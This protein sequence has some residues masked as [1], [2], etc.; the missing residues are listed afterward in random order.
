L[1]IRVAFVSV[2]PSPYQRDLFGAL[3]SRDELDLQVF[4]LERT[5]PDSPWPETSLRPFESILPGFCLPAGGVRTHFNVPPGLGKFDLV[6]LNSLMAATAQWLMRVQLRYRKWVFWGER[7]R[8]TTGGFRRKTHGALCSVLKNATAIAAVGTRAKTDYERRFPGVPVYNI[9][10]H[11]NLERFQNAAAEK[12]ESGPAPIFLFCGQMIARKGI[13][14]LLKAFITLVSE[15]PAVRLLL[16]GREAELPLLLE[17]L[18]PEVGDR[19]EY[20][21]FQ[22]PADLPRFFARGDIFVLPSRYDGWGVVVNQAIGAGLPI[23]CSDEVGAGYDLVS[24]GVNGERFS[25][26][27]SLLNAMRKMTLDESYRRRSAAASA[28]LIPDWTPERGAEKWIA[29]IRQIFR[30]P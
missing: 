12:R 7:L 17:T 15:H 11:C 16:I 1:R 2:L 28:A 3:A 13:D 8:G 29:A 6:V 14:L 20:A 18:P 21:G 25:D 26:E 23:I 5:T 19:I 27:Y 30:L 10:Y 9:P 4:Y 22:A 24:P